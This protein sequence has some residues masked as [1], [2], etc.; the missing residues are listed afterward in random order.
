MQPTDRTDYPDV[1]PACSQRGDEAAGADGEPAADV[2]SMIAALQQFEPGT[3]FEREQPAMQERAG[4]G[5]AVPFAPAAS[6]GANPTRPL[7]QRS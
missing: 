4:S 5:P 6:D 2:N 1:A 7:K 3:V